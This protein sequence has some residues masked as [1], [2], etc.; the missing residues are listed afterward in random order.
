M[1]EN[2]TQQPTDGR[3]SG[4]ALADGSVTNPGNS[5]MDDDNVICPYCGA[6]YNAESEDFSED[7]R[8]EECAECGRTYLLHD[9][10]TVT[11]HTRTL[12]NTELGRAERRP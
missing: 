2:K 7:E 8:E 1:N 4:L 5:E 6:E 11:H 9:E 10:C 3:S 12:P